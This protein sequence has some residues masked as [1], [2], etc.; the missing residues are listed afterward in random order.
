MQTFPAARP[1]AGFTLVEM[2]VLFGLIG[3]ITAFA[4]PTFSA[5]QRR[6]DAR[7][8]AQYV[9][10]TLD[11]ARTLAIKE[12]NPYIV[13]FESDGSLTVIDD[14]D[15]DWETDAGELQRTIR[16]PAAH[17]GVGPWQTGSPAASPVPEDED[18][19]ITSIPNGGV[20]FPEDEVREM[21][22]IGFTTQGFP[23]SLP[24]TVTDP[25]GAPGSGAGTYYITDND[26]AVYAA[27][28]LPLGGTRLRLYRPSI[29][30]WH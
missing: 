24:P 8:Q 27:T 22:G 23:I 30:D 9:S 12:S 6:Q 15:G 26:D 19:G 29:G 4:V 10:D 1:T 21:P 2:C 20:T 7:E 17:G 3:A 28:L 13:L 5:Y 16:P 25:P 14:D 18:A 11:Q